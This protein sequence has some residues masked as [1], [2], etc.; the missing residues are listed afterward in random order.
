MTDTQEPFDL[1]ELRRRQKSRSRIM[2]LGLIGL[3]A[4]FFFIT[5]AK[6]GLAS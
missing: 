1:T 4:L 6:M 2:G 3:A 5:I